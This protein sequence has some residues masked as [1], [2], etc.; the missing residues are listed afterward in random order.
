[1]ISP[2]SQGETSSTSLEGSSDT[3]NQKRKRG[4]REKGSPMRG[5]DTPPMKKKQL[6]KRLLTLEQ[7]IIDALALKDSMCLT[8]SKEMVKSQRDLISNES[9]MLHAVASNN[10]LTQLSAE[11]E[12]REK[13]LCLLYKERNQISHYVGRS[14]M[15]VLGLGPT[16]SPF[17]E[18]IYYALGADNESI[19]TNETEKTR[20][21]ASLELAKANLSAACR[22]TT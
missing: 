14:K 9:T 17:M 12:S 1:M 22:R 4:R 8:I 5:D 15:L 19:E 3:I 20:E 2:R 18:N 11:I 6:T 16:G 7:K 13:E 10:R 21:S